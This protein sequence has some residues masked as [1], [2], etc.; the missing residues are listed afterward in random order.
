VLFPTLL[1]T[2]KNL[3]LAQHYSVSAYITSLD[4]TTLAAES[5]AR[6]KVVQK[7]LL[8]YTLQLQHLNAL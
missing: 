6:K 4:A 8:K 2:L 1:K 7:Q 3:N 5:F